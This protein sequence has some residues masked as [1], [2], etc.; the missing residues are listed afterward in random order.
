MDRLVAFFEGYMNVSFA[1]I[2]VTDVV[3]MAIIA[4]LLYEIMLWIKNTRVWILLKGFLVLIGFII[5]AA[6]FEMNTILWIADK[7]FNIGILALVIIFQPELRK[8]LEQLGQNNVFSHFLQNGN[9]KNRQDKMSKAVVEGIV[10][11]AFEMSKTRTG[12]L[13]VLEKDIPLTEYIATGIPIDGVVTSQLLLNIFEHNTP[14]HDG[15]V[16]IRGNRVVSATCYLP[17]SDSMKISKAL[18]TRHRAGLGIS[19]ITDS[20]TVIVSEETGYVSAALE[21]RLVRHM[22]AEGLTALLMQ[23]LVESVEEQPKRRLLKGRHKNEKKI[24][25]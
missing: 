10:H 9:G 2:W 23:N 18:G 24:D 3:E 11:A 17:L 19:E 20:I 21:G 14:L 25:K 12:A 1:D 15:A 5:V 16:I 8:A 7:V 4:F 22:N 6:V 13:I